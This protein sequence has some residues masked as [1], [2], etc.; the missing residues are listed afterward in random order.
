MVIV[1]MFVF[2]RYKLHVWEPDKQTQS[3][4]TSRA[5]EVEGRSSVGCGGQCWSMCAGGRVVVAGI[6]PRGALNL[7]GL[8]PARA[9][10]G[11]RE[12]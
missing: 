5:S 4:T 3:F 10:C 7:G 1:D 12:A 8:P 2:K 6:L 11:R 9:P